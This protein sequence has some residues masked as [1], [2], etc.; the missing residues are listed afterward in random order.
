MGRKQPN[1]PRSK[2]R[3]AI[4]QLWMR[5]RERAKAL[6]STGYCCSECGI[7]QSKAK[8]R[9]VKIE[10]HHEPPIEDKWKEIIDLIAKVI[11]EAPQYPVCKS[12][13][14]EKHN[15]TPHKKLP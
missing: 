9:A 1:T 5:S 12:C 4:R 2:I 14:K 10:V 7:K 6:K 13:H 15:A 11:L 8:G 3:S